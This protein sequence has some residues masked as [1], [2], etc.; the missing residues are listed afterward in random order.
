MLIFLFT[1]L[2][3]FLSTFIAA[4]F[5]FRAPTDQAIR[6]SVSIA[7]LVT[8]SLLAGTQLVSIFL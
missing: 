3:G 6:D 5:M 7:L 1:F 8:V 2:Y 4:K